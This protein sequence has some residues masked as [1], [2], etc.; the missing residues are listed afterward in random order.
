M[1]SQNKCYLMSNFSWQLSSDT[2]DWWMKCLEAGNEKS[3]LLYHLKV[4]LKLIDY[5]LQPGKIRDGEMASVRE[6]RVGW[7]M[8]P[9]IKPT[10]AERDVFASAGGVWWERVNTWAVCWIKVPSCSTAWRITATNKDQDGEKT[11]QDLCANGNWPCRERGDRESSPLSMGQ[12]ATSFIFFHT[13]LAE[14]DKE[15]WAVLL[16]QLE[17]LVGDC[18]ESLAFPGSRFI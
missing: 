9:T 11:F 1:L 16:H 12:A 18:M 2:C 6:D 8:H 7:R 14:Q 5:T 13:S 15:G 3:S 10:F 17:T 4:S